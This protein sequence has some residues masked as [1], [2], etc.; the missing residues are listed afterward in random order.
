MLVSIPVPYSI[1]GPGFSRFPRPTEERM[2]LKS[3]EHFGDETCFKSVAVSFLR[4]GRTTG[5][6]G[7]RAVSFFSYVGQ[8]FS[9]KRNRYMN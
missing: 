8:S 3:P 1:R 7:C 4:Q 5:Y 6:G 2:T 9:A